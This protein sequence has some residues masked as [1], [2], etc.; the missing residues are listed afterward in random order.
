[1]SGC[2]GP[3]SIARVDRCLMSA[4]VVTR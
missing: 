1:M 2:A 3:P 4:I